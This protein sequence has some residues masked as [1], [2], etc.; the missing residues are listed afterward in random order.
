[1]VPKSA[2]RCNRNMEG[3]EQTQL[4]ALRMFFGVVSVSRDGGPTGETAS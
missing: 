4:R 2:W 3:V 1:M